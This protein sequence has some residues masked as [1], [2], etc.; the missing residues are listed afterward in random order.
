VKKNF[1]REDNKAYGY[2]AFS[3]V[4]CGVVVSGVGPI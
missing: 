3:Y 2:D 1:E 4:R